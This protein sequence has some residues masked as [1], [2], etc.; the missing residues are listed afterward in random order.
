MELYAEWQDGILLSHSTGLRQWPLRELERRFKLEKK[1]HLMQWRQV[2][3]I[4]GN[5]GERLS[6]IYAILRRLPNP[7][8]DTGCSAGRQHD[9]L[10]WLSGRKLCAFVQ[11]G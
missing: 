4:R 2:D 9:H 11:L 5:I 1:Q 3:K 10:P 7:S 6:I 8:G